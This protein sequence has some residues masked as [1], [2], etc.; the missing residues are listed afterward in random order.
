MAVIATLPF[1]ANAGYR[2]N[3]VTAPVR[4][5]N[6]GTVQRTIYYT[7]PYATVAIEED[8]DE[9]IASTAYVKGAYNDTIA[10]LNGRQPALSNTGTG[11]AMGSDVYGIEDFMSMIDDEDNELLEQR[12][13]SGAAVI[14]GIKSQRVEVYTN[15]DDDD[16]TTDVAFKT[17]VPED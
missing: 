4:V 16:A 12:L 14:A 8:D 3:D 7:E 10:G 5:P 1:S 15:W 13:I 17:V 11:D 6:N 2:Y 9:H